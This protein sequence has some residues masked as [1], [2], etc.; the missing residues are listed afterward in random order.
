MNY[1]GTLYRNSRIS[2]MLNDSNE[3]YCGCFISNKNPER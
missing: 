3:N 1:E 2:R